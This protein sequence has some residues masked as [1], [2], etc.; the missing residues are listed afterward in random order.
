MK[1]F[2][3]AGFKNSGKTTLVVE[4]IKELRQR[5]LR[6]ATIKHAHHKFDIDHPGKDSHQHREAGAEEVIVASSRRWAHIRELDDADEPSVDELLQHLGDVDLVLIEGYK[7]GLHPKLE[8][9]RIGRDAPEMAGTDNSIKAVVNDG[10]AETAG[11]P[12]LDRSDVPAI[13][14]FILAAAVAV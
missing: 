9:R 3:I 1:L 13:A 6:V 5:G 10:P 7:H 12:L 4:L 8:L 2:G 11:L 14:D